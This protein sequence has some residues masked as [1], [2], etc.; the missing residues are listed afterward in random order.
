MTTAAETK[1]SE[2]V[3]YLKAHA[4]E[5]LQEA[6][7]QAG[8][9]RGTAPPNLRDPNFSF[10]VNKPSVVLPSFSIADFLDEGDLSEEVAR[11]STQT[12]D[13]FAE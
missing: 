2:T 13:W 10:D 12:D 11:L 1:Y 8:R 7:N 9:I 5:T 4:D 6:L 3:T